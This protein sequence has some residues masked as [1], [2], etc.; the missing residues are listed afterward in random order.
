MPSAATVAPIFSASFPATLAAT[1]SRDNAEH[2]CPPMPNALRT[3]P[4]AARSRSA[5]AVT[6][7]AFLPPISAMHGFG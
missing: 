7:Q 5:F 1:Y 3:M 2:F 4:A 6:M